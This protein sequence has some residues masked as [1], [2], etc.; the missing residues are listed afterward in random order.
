MTSQDQQLGVF[1]QDDWV[2]NDHLTLNLGLRW[3]IE[4]NESYLDSR[5]RNS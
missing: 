5:R 2:V 3:D 4:W 1:A